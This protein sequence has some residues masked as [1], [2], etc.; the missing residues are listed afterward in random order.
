MAIFATALGET[1]MCAHWVFYLE[2][3]FS[4][5]FIWSIFWYNIVGNFGSVDP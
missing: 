1:E 5:T 4:T 3:L 2:I